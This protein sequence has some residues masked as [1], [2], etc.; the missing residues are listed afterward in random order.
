MKNTIPKI[1]LSLF[2]LAVVLIWVQQLFHPIKL[3]AL[4]GAYDPGEWPPLTYNSWVS[5]NYQ[6][7]VDHYLKYHTAFNGE[8]VRLRNQV[9]YSLF[10]NINTMLVL[11]KD[12]YIFDPSY[13]AAIEGKDLVH[14]SVLRVQE[15]NVNEFLSEHNI[16][17][18]FVFA[19]N[20]S[21]FYAELLPDSLT[22]A[23]KTNK[24]LFKELLHR[25]NVE[26]IDF[27]N[28]FQSVGDTSR[29]P[30]IPKYGAHWSTL[31]AAYA[32]DS[33][34]KKLSQL[35]GTEV[36][37]YQ[38]LSVDTSS[39]ARYQDD[40]YLPSLNLMYKWRSPVLAYPQLKFTNGK[41]PNVLFISDSFIW[42]FY[43]IGMMQHCLDGNSHVIY[44]FKTV[45]DMQRN[46]LGEAGQFSMNQILKNRDV[47]IILSS[48]PSLKDFAFGFFNASNK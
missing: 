27:D 25:A 20:K 35:T 29:W 21:G 31:G 6:S 47:I 46:N 1:F 44:Y 39:E 28:W 36:P 14:D 8:L 11:G 5:G 41:K 17:V 16:P 24:S 48:D 4:Q 10:G 33:L 15:I 26:Y 23:S 2:S 38:I 19:P 37:G 3:A 22:P 40:D 7:R 9:D 30:L 42:N 45:Y 13:A 18:L 12:Q 34:M 43:D 32:G